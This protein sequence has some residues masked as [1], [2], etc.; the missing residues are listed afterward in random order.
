MHL[1]YALVSYIASFSINNQARKNNLADLIFI[2]I[3]F[4]AFSTFI[5]VIETLQP[6]IAIK[7]VELLKTN[8]CIQTRKDY[9]VRCALI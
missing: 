3:F 8:R 5:H 7:W 4:N 2:V 6:L 1:L 9:H